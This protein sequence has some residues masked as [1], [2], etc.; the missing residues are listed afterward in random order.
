MQSHYGSAKD[1][2]IFSTTKKG[3]DCEYNTFAN[4]VSLTNDIVIF[5]LCALLSK[6]LT[7]LH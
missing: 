6:R 4:I 3:N 5:E 1:P 7:S 2:H